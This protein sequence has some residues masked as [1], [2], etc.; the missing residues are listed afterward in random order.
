MTARIEPHYLP[1]LEFFCALV[2]CDLVIIEQ[3]EHFVKQTYRNR[4]YINT[5][6][7]K[8]ILSVPLHHR[9]GK[10]LFKEVRMED[11]TH[12]RN[13]HWR[14]IESAYRSSPYFEFYSDELRSI[15]FKTHT[16]L[17]DL[18]TELLSFCLKN[19]KWDKKIQKTSSY[20]VSTTDE[21][22]LRNTISDRIPYSSRNFYR[23]VPY[24]QVFGNEFAANLSVVDL[25]FC[26]GPGSGEVI[27]AS[28]GLA[29][30]KK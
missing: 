24:G 29:N 22:D 12:W 25:L 28:H 5:A 26:E 1:S 16:F 13:T 7:G 9:H 21:V 20:Q 19:I 8:K 4:C 30:K 18:N 23:A 11:G 17:I 3:H 15:L 27:R 14:T 6:Q 2:D 10:I